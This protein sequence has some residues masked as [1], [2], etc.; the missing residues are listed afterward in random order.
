MTP[1]ITKFN[2]I[3]GD[4][5]ITIPIPFTLKDGIEYADMM[6]ADIPKYEDTKDYNVFD[7]IRENQELKKQLETIGKK[8]E[9]EAKNRDKVYKMLRRKDGQQKEFI[10][11]LEQNIE[12]EEYCYLA[13]N[14][15]ER[16]R[17]D[18]FEEVLSKYKEIIG[19][20]DE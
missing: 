3:T 18:V 5:E 1:I 4:F 19:V 12:N 7:L 13:Q 20:K 8:Y 10:E 11:W 16:C 6:I 14:P 17:K 9:F 15:S 2:D